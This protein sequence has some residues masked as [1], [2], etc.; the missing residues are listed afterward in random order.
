[1]NKI[2]AIVTTFNNQ[3]T[4]ENTTPGGPL[5]GAIFLNMVFSM[6][7]RALLVQ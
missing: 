6:E 7:V 2:S 1:M 5:F 4:L 3:L